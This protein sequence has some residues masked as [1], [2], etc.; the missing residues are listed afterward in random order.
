MDYKADLLLREVVTVGPKAKIIE[1]VRLMRDKH[2]GCVVITD[3]D[4]VCGVFTERDVLNKVV[5]DEV[6]TAKTAV[7]K[8]MTA[9]PVTVESS[10]PL[11]KIFEI[12][13]RQRFRHVPIVD[14][15]K[16]VGMVSLSDFAGVLRE[17]FEEPKY[18]Q[19]F[20]DYTKAR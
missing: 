16:A 18:L 2:I 15:G 14:D 7:S 20:V 10:A 8:Y 17:V 12:L 1:V 5:P 6:D 13:S 9:D 11:E 19:Y 3:N 4:K